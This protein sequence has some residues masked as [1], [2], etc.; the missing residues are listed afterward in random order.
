MEFLKIDAKNM[1]TSLLHMANYIRNKKVKK[2]KINDV[3]KL[4]GFGK[5]AWNFISSIYKSG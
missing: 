1:F 3:P 4:N 5:V 2:G